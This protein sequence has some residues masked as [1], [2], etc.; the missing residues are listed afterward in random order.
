[1]AYSKDQDSPK[2]YRFWK[3]LTRPVNGLP[4][5]C[6]KRY[7]ELCAKAV[8][9]DLSFGQKVEIWYH[10]VACPLCWPVVGQ[11]VGLKMLCENLKSEED[12][13]SEEGDEE[14]ECLSEEEKA[15]LRKALCQCEQK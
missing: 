8:D 4:G 12:E 10:K 9:E 2:F 7:V 5:V 13:L 15:A 1:M 14:G 11:Y 6:C 3:K